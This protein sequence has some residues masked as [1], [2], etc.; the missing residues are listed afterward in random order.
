MLGCRRK[1]SP[2][3]GPARFDKRDVAC[4]VRF[5]IIAIPGGGDESR[6]HLTNAQ[7]N[8][9]FTR[10]TNCEINFG[11][12]A[13]EHRLLMLRTKKA[14]Y[15]RITGI[16]D[17][18]ARL[19]HRKKHLLH[20]RHF[21][22]SRFRQNSLDFGIHTILVFRKIKIREYGDIGFRQ[23]TQKWNVHIAQ[24]LR[25]VAD[26]PAAHLDGHPADLIGHEP[27]SH[28]DA[29]CTH[30]PSFRCNPIHVVVR[31][32]S[33]IFIQRNI[34]TLLDVRQQKLGL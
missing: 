9:T 19:S 30:I 8:V 16:I 5:G 12:K 27:A 10:E 21:N 31:I 2:A 34:A 13:V 15:V 3:K 25:L 22:S 6:R 26:A 32:V 20:T 18:P 23:A 11:F 1:Q 7:T 33:S 14:N 4:G 24:I 29:Q 17:F 28:D